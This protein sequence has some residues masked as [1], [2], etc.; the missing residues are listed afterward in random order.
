MHSNQCRNDIHAPS[1]SRTNSV[2]ATL[3]TMHCV[4]SVE[5]CT[6]VDLRVNGPQERKIW[7]VV[8]RFTEVVWTLP[9][10]QQ[11]WNLFSSSV[12]ISKVPEEQARNLSF[13]GLQSSL[14]D[15]IRGIQ[16]VRL[17]TQFVSFHKVSVK[18]MAKYKAGTRVWEILDSPLVIALLVKRVDQL[19][20]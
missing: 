4:K 12:L 10:D 5:A 3:V 17:H 6:V 14:A 7:T 2:A 15:F 19:K 18:K 13:L 8:F 16:E 20:L 1:G 9:L 11:L